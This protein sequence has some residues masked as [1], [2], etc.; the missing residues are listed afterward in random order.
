MNAQAAATPL[1]RVAPP[2]APRAFDIDD[3]V[4]AS[5]EMLARLARLQSAYQGVT[6]VELMR[7][8]IEKEFVEEV[9]IVSSFG[10]ES[11]VLLHLVAQVDPSV[12]V[13]FLNTGKLFGETLRY[14]DRLQEVVG[15]TDIRAIGPHPSDLRRHDPDGV[16]WNADPDQCCAIRKVW[17]LKKALKNF[18][19][20]VTGRKR[21][22]TRSRS[23]MDMIEISDGR[24]KI[25]PLAHWSHED[26][27]RYTDAH[28]LPK[29]PLLKDGYLSIGCMP[30]TS[31][32]KEGED[33]RSG[34][35]SG[36]DKDECGI[37]EPSLTDGDGI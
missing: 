11:A 25:N 16:L 21:F 32:V 20:Q 19:A 33:Y 29:H 35:W 14:R 17:P 18:S 22:Q 30:C 36:L 34:R 13:I 15:L 12:P 5:P 31:R 26:L 24:F 4:P 28:K 8:M 1:K 23:A 2:K 3:G 27:E 10:A 7:S 6:G 37:H 9:A